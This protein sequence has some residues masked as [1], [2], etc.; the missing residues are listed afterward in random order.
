MT[1][2]AGNRRH[3]IVVLNTPFVGNQYELVAP[4]TVIGRSPE[5][6]IQIDLV[7]ISRQHACVEAVGGRFFVRDMG[8]RNG[9][10]VNDR[11]ASRVELRGD[12][13]IT[14]GEANLRFETP[15]EAEALSGA[16]PQT[17]SSGEAASARPLTGGDIVAATR[18]ATVPCAQP[19]G[20]HAPTAD[21]SPRRAMGKLA[22]AAIVGIV[23]AM[24]VGYW[25]VA[26]SQ[27]QEAQSGLT[28]Q[29]VI[30]RVNEN[31][32]V[33]FNISHGE[34]R[35]ESIRIA[36]PSVADAKE[37]GGYLLATGKAGGETDVAFR[38][39]K[40]KHG[41]LRV[42]VRGRMDDPIGDLAYAGLNPT[43]RKKAAAEFYDRGVYKES[44]GETY[45]ALQEYRKAVAV[46]DP[47][48]GKG[49]LY[50]KAVRKAETLRSALSEAWDR[51]YSEMRI[52]AK[53]G[54]LTRVEA[55]GKEVMALFPDPND[56]RYQ[57][58][59]AIRLA[60]IQRMLR[61]R[62]HRG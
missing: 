54:N 28:L 52:A 51:L 26:S 46:L 29:S 22:I 59:E 7:S 47:L 18:R 6:A 56:A 17:A 23:I 5:C 55:V 57:L 62:Q 39:E 25:V 36:D 38:T 32:L 37:F 60:L 45:L 53:D 11:P 27:P 13:V 1:D 50:V 15:A 41:A 30:V 31:R 49:A 9:I 35:P 4:I 12:D 34:V 2:L 33:L 10:R 48:G 44:G 58:A 3:R 43:E 24:G 40:G 19:P 16:G 14:V 8:S 42:L 20:A 21:P 61:E